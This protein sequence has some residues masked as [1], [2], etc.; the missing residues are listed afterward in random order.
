MLPVERRR[1]LQDGV[2]L[3][4]RYVASADGGEY[5]QHKLPGSYVLTASGG[6]LP[7]TVTVEVS[8]AHG[9]QFCDSV[10]IK[11]G[12][13]RYVQSTDLRRIPLGRLLDEALPL[14]MQEVS[15]SGQG[16][17]ISPAPQRPVKRRGR[18]PASEARLQEVVDAW[19]TEAALGGP[20][21]AA[22]TAAALGVSTSQFH[23]LR[24][25]AEQRG[26]THA[27]GG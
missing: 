14:V 22:R 2:S 11:G 15:S 6:T 23:R 5:A 24:R 7:G 13:A 10:T 21:I 12:E 25:L 20:N 8:I 4:A 17:R 18:P 19:A 1:R 27:T 3:E 26:I 16:W 9:Q